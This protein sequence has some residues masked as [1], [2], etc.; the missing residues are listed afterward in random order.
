MSPVVRDGVLF[1]GDTAGCLYSID[2]RGGTLRAVRT[3]DAPFS[4]SPPLLVN[5]ALIVVVG[6][7]IRALRLRGGIVPPGGS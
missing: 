5:D 1:A 3:F 2:A 7:T 6:Q 4:T